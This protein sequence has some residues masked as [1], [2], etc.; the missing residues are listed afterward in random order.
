MHLFEYNR[1][2]SKLLFITSSEIGPNKN[3]KHKASFSGFNPKDYECF[4]KKNRVQR[5]LLPIFYTTENILGFFMKSKWIKLR[6][7]V[8]DILVSVGFKS[9]SRVKK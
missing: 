1:K 9:F 5:K 8:I 2:E 7:W 6:G 4:F 3:F